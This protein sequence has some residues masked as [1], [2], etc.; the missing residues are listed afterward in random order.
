[1]RAHVFSGSR[2]Y[3]EQKHGEIFLDSH[4]ENLVHLQEVKVTNM[5]WRGGYRVR[6]LTVLP[7]PG[8]AP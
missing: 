3:Y 6:V 1:M 7:G 2:P 8:L 4:H 5:G